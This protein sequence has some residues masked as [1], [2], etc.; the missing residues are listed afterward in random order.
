MTSTEIYCI[1]IYDRPFRVEH[2]QVYHQPH[3]RGCIEIWR[4]TFLNHCTGYRK[5]AQKQGRRKNRRKNHKW[6]FQFRRSGCHYG[7]WL[8]KMDTLQLIPELPRDINHAIK[9]T[10]F[11][12]LEKA[13]IAFPAPIWEKSTMSSLNGE[14]TARGTKDT[15][16]IFTRFLRPNY[17]PKEQTWTLEMVSLSSPAIFGEDARPVLM[18]GDICCPYDI[19]YRGPESLQRRIL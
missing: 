11:S 1:I 5:P 18:L 3:L 9:D 17:V 16:P 10:S 4:R 15:F 8:S 13:F 19:S 7:A 12:C 2:A 14:D 6:K